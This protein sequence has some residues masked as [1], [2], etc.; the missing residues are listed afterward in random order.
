[1]QL[2]LQITFRHMEPS[3]A[4]EARV[5]ERAGKL[6]Q[7]FGH[8]M[9]CRVV[10]EAPHRHHHQGTLYEVRVDVTV[11]GGELAASRD[12][13]RNHAHEDVHVAVRDAFDAIERQLEDHARRERQEVKTH[14]AVPHGRISELVP[15][16]DYGRILTPEGRE[17]YFHRHSVVDGNFDRLVVGDEVHF[18]EE[19]GEQGP[20]A[21]TV[22]VRGKSHGGG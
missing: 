20:Q 22:H 13:G 5:R 1:M 11:P 19:L 10:I 4:V 7:I 21:S 3:A 18:S 2:P 14:E 16:E 12:A 8:I 15:A 9:A 17:L 6:D